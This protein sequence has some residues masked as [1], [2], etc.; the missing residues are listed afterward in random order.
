MV[1]LGTEMMVPCIKELLSWGLLHR[2]VD[3]TWHRQTPKQACSQ[4]MN[5]FICR[6]WEGT[7]N[8]NLTWIHCRLSDYPSFVQLSALPAV[9]CE[10]LPIQIF[11]VQVTIP[12][13]M[14]EMFL[15]SFMNWDRQKIQKTF[16]VSQNLFSRRKWSCCT[17][18]GVPCDA[19]LR[20]QESRH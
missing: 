3:C 11:K 19:V 2:R 5:G 14:R 9:A 20:F 8:Y 17:L 7:V 15:V 1:I 6:W 4:N 18:L 13:R 12:Y 16:I 10:T